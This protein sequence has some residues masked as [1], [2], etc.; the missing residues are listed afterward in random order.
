VANEGFV[1]MYSSY[2]NRLRKLL[3]IVNGLMAT[4]GV[5]VVIF[6]VVI[7]VKRKSFLAV[8]PRQILQ[9]TLQILHATH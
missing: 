5:T 8:P 7:I 1:A 4:Y 3:G 6:Q 9:F 2:F